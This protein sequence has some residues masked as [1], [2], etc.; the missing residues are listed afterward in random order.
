LS[1]FDELRAALAAN[2]PQFYRG[3]TV[4][5]YGY[6]RP[7]A[8]VSEGIREHRWSQGMM[9]GL[10]AHCDCIKAFSET[11]SMEDLKNINNPV[12]ITHR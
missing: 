4:P 8:K 9:G 7:G 2:R 5:F 10:K 11:D 3:I 12:L 1:A 6:S